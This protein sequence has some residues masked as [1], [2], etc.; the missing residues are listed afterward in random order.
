MKQKHVGWIPS[1]LWPEISFKQPF[2]SNSCSSLL[3]FKDCMW[4]CGRV[5]SQTNHLYHVL[6]L[7]KVALWTQNLKQRSWCYVFLKIICQVSYNCDENSKLSLK[8]NKL[9]PC[10]WDAAR[11]MLNRLLSVH[12]VKGSLKLPCVNYIIGVF[13]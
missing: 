3:N 11:G 2:R 5:A 8:L 9:C 4:L 10:S 6:S 7:F 13:C 1:F 12:M